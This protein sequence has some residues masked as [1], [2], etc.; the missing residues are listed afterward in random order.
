[1]KIKPKVR[2]VIAIFVLAAAM[3]GNVAKW[4][5]RVRIGRHAGGC[6]TCIR[7]MRATPRRQ[8]RRLRSH[9]RTGGGTA[10]GSTVSLL[11]AQSNGNMRMILRIDPVCYTLK[12]S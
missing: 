5:W 7:P 3:V 10:A 2:K 6:A 8:S 11:V 12:P 1:M 4:R 9:H